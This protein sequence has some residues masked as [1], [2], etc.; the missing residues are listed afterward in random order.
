[1]GEAYITEL[2]YVAILS[3]EHDPGCL[4][5]FLQYHYQCGHTSNDSTSLKVM[6]LKISVQSQPELIRTVMSLGTKFLLVWT[7][8]QL[9]NPNSGPFRSV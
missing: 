9:L 2:A 6:F 1:M 8:G 4:G 7:Q 3:R 5:R